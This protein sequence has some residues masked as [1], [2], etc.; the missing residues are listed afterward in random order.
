M[1]CCYLDDAGNTGADL[2]DAEQPIH[3]T[4]ALMVP[5]YAWMKVSDE[6]R[7]IRSYART[8]GYQ[9]PQD[10]N[11]EF[12]GKEIFQ[13]QRHG[14]GWGA[15]SFPDRLDVYRR[16]LD[17]ALRGKLRLALGCCDKRLLAARYAHPEHPHAIAMWLCLERVAKFAKSHSTLALLL[18]DDCSSEV[19]EITRKVLGDYRRKGAPFGGTVDFSYL[20]DTVHFVNSA[21][22]AHIQLCD[23]ILY[24]IRRAE[25]KPSPQIQPLADMAVKTIWAR[26]TIPY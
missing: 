11:L 21:D 23:L 14:E 12:H 8:K 16:C 20:I 2:T 1:L 15:V 17:T 13:G 5:D 10:S 6:I 18:A 19:R 7:G 9:S 4:G 24:A 25:S 22:S 3:Y 26:R